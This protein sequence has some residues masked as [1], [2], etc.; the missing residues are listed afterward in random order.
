MV[1]FYPPSA[2]SDGFPD[3]PDDYSRERIVTRMHKDFTMSHYL[4]ICLNRGLIHHPSRETAS[5][6]VGAFHRN[7]ARAL[8]TSMQ[9]SLASHLVQ[10][11]VF[12]SEHEA[13]ALQDTARK[14]RIRAVLSSSAS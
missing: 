4:D 9:V 7:D 6:L 12:A 2:V 5:Y 13:F 1:S 10:K 11:A 3:D 8:F 14:R